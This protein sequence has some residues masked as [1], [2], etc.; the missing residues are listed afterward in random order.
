MPLVTVDYPAGQLSAAQKAELAEDLTRVLLEVEGGGDTPF[1]RAG[2]WVL[3]RELPGADWFVGG[4]NDGTYVSGS[5]RFLVELTVPEGVLDQQRVSDAHRAT[6]DAVARVLGV[7][8]DQTHSVWVQVTQ[9]PEGHLAS[10]GRT[11][12]LFGI[13]RRAGHPAGHPVL[14]FPRAYFDA[15][16][17]WYT[18]NDFPEQTSGR[19]L[20]RY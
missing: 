15:K 18:A 10:G 3:F 14:G 1:G 8:G 16:G 7:A 5:G 9:W 4:V 13:A 17:R 12:G 11:V 20:D 6:T 2:S 19:P